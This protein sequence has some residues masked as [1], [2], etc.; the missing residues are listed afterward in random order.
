G[1][2]ARRWPLWL[3]LAALFYGAILLLVYAHHN[4]IADF[5]SPPFLWKV[6]YG[7]AFAAF[8]AAM[9]FTL[10]TAS[11]RLSRSNLSLLDAMQPEAYGIFLFHYVFIIWLQYVV[12]ELAIGAGVKAAIVFA[13]TLSGSW[14]LTAVLRKIPLVARTI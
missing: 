3:G 5:V 4:W 9:A 2:I 12:Y 1:E 6:A 10:L 14:L 7:L 8:S 13:G 11:L